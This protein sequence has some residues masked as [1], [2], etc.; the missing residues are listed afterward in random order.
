ME[1]AHGC[2]AA[3]DTDRAIS[4]K[5]PGTISI[6]ASI[7]GDFAMAYDEE[8]AERVR[9]LLSGRRDVV[10]KKMM[11]GLC[12][13]VS[14][15]M[16]CAVSGRGGLLVRVGPEAHARMAAE[17]HATAAEM[18]E[19]IMTGYVRVAPEGYQTDAALKKW[20]ERGLAFVATM[21]TDK[22]KKAPTKKG[23]AK[24]GAAKKVAAKPKPARLVAW[25]SKKQNTR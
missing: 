4:P 8:T 12:F 3:R 1:A 2:I 23:I 15:Y 17:P 24:K 13:M 21:P 5:R 7:G 19:R 14:G 10:A 11:G 6:A 25:Q 18:R 9:K 20:V 16:C 22:T